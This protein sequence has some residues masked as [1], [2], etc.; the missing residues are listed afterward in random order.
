MLKWYSLI[1]RGAR[2]SVCEW[3]SKKSPRDEGG[4]MVGGREPERRKEEHG[5]VEAQSQKIALCACD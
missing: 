5:G 2:D 3:N 4:C 1:D